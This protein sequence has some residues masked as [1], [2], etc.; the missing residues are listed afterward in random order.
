MPLPR[1]AAA[2][3]LAMCGVPSLARPAAPRVHTVTLGPVR[4][5]PYVAADAARET[6]DDEMGVLRVRALTV[7][8]KLREW[9]TGD[10]HDVTDRSFVT[11]RVL[12]V[13]DM[14]PNEK[15]GRWVW[16]PGPWLLVDRVSGRITALHLPDFDS[17]ISGVVWYR[18]YAAYCGI[19]TAAKG[20]G[21]SAEVWQIGAHRAALQKVIG[22]WPQTE[23][24][25]PVCAPAAWQREPM[26]VTLRATGGDPLVF[27]VVG[28][29][30]L[31][32]E[33][34]EGGD[35]ENP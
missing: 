4:R 32:V 12:H 11:R 27:S 33:D 19:H 18:D 9:T 2:L 25:R 6:K 15:A 3:L 14:L 31:L 29:S 28:T 16:Q 8:G 5:L 34:G 22:P 24:V 20:G 30:S 10:Q 21:L 26:R 7:D 35:D 23:R 17:S 1:A 13:N